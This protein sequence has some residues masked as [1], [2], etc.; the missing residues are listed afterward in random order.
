MEKE[1]LRLMRLLEHWTQ[2]NDEH[3][4]KYRESADQAK[5]IGLVKVAEEMTL[6]ADKSRDVS[7]HLRKALEKMQGNGT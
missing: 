3:R 5:K 4:K 2:H 6:A 7:T 1:K